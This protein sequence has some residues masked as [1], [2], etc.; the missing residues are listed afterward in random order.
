[1][2]ILVLFFIGI[3]AFLVLIRPSSKVLTVLMMAIFVI[4]IAGTHDSYDYNQ[5]VIMYSRAASGLTTTVSGTWLLTQLMRLGTLLGLEYDGF[6]LI[7]TIIESLIIQLS[8]R[9]YCKNTAFAWLLFILFPGWWLSTLFRH[10]IA[11]TILI[12]SLRFL[13]EDKKYNTI[14]YLLCVIIAGMFHSAFWFF[15][16]LILIKFYDEKTILFAGGISTVVLFTAKQIS[17]INNLLSFLRIEDDIALRIQGRTTSFVGSFLTIIHMFP[18]LLSG[19]L[20]YWINI[21][22]LS[23]GNKEKEEM[24]NEELPIQKS[25]IR[26]CST[27]IFCICMSMISSL[28]SRL[29]HFYSVFFIIICANCLDKYRSNETGRFLIEFLFVVG[30][31]ILTILSCIESK[32]LYELIIKAIF[33][34]NV[35]LNF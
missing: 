8:L 34:T 5:Y 35:F 16:I 6:R 19:I 18:V 14:K 26:I 1:M 24:A 10:T 33:D 32:S 3:I 25:F 22:K 31:V 30:A 29:C 27:Y 17:F 4:M 12:W 20:A 21:G 15:L 13:V 11:L 7:I 23:F 9:R 2:N 28:S